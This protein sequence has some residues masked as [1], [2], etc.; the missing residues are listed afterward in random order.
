MQQ[1]TQDI[2][3]M[4]SAYTNLPQQPLLF[5]ANIILA[6]GSAINNTPIGVL[7]TYAFALQQENLQRIDINPALTAYAD[8]TVM[9]KYAALIAYIH[10]LGMQVAINPEYDSVSDASITTFGAYQNAAAR[11]CAAFASFS[12]DNIVLVHE[13]T[14]T[15]GRI[16]I[17]ANTNISVTPQQWIPFIETASAAVKKV[18]PTTKVGAGIYIGDNVEL[19]Y[20]QS[21]AQSSSLDFLTFDTYVSG[22]NAT[23]SMDT[24]V[25]IA[26]ESEKPLYIEETWHPHNPVPGSQF[27]PG[28]NLDSQDLVGFGY[29]GFEL[30][31]AE[32][33]NAMTLYASTHGLEA[34]TAFDSTCFFLYVDEP[35]YF[36]AGYLTQVASALLPQTQTTMTYVSYRL[37]TENTALTSTSSNSASL[38]AS[39]NSSSVTTSPRTTT[40]NNAN[41][42]SATSGQ[43]TTTAAATTTTNNPNSTAAPSTS[44]ATTLT[45]NTQNVTAAPSTSSNSSA[46]AAAPNT[47]TTISAATVSS[48]TTSSH[49]SAITISATENPSATTSAP[50]AVSSSSSANN[51]L[52]PDIPLSNPALSSSTNNPS[53]TSTGLPSDSTASFTTSNSSVVSSTAVNPTTSSV[54]GNATEAAAV[55]SPASAPANANLSDMEPILSSNGAISNSSGMTDAL[56]PDTSPGQDATAVSTD[57]TLEQSNTSSNL[58]PGLISIDDQSSGQAG[59]TRKSPPN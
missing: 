36:G 40:A 45:T 6:K 16:N 19:P 39:T 10:Q 32:W 46:A 44:T 15:V 47:A 2:N 30:L 8:T 58:P 51:S 21:F 41:S 55:A 23:A 12:P 4:T 31:D 37:A 11:D 28:E 17:S 50:N 7:K 33:L 1:T 49:N 42:P 14:T 29:Q 24:L 22:E 56:T 53:T 35:P 38:T 54:S 48:A 52:T 26:Q 9:N 27:I 20:F 13:P 59:L 18:S 43:S 57:L 5:S 34:I 25:Q 3:V